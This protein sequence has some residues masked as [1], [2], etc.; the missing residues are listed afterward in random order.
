MQISTE[1]KYDAARGMKT[2]DCYMHLPENYHTE[3]RILRC[4]KCKYSRS[5]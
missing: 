3:L 2:N 1:Y 4:E 5:A